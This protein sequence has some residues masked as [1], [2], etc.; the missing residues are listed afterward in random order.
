MYVDRAKK[1]ARV[2]Q[3]MRTPD[4]YTIVRRSHHVVSKLIAP[5]AV[6]EDELVFLNFRPAYLKAQRRVYDMLWLRECHIC[7]YVTIPELVAKQHS[8]K[9]PTICTRCYA[10]LNIC[11]FCRHPI[12]AAAGHSEQPTPQPIDRFVE[13]TPASRALL[14][15]RQTQYSAS[16]GPTVL[17]RFAFS[18]PPHT[19]VARVLR[20]QFNREFNRDVSTRDLS[21]NDGWNNASETVREVGM[22]INFNDSH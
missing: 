2:V 5:P 16:I 20:E 7:M 11:P 13:F 21:H 10:R 3:E 19:S 22:A 18:P 4:A 15:D 8:D 1:N 14:V 6:A 12:Q 9:H 17:R